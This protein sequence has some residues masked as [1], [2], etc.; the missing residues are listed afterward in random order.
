MNWESTSNWRVLKDFD[1]ASF[2]LDL[3]KLQKE[4]FLVG[5]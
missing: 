4:I 3:C 2:L 5:H 1:K